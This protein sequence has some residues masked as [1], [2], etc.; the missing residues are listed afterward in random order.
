MSLRRLPDGR[1]ALGRYHSPGLTI[2]RQAQTFVPEIG[3]WRQNESED[4]EDEEEGEE[5]DDDDYD[6]DDDDADDDVDRG[7]LRATLST[8]RRSAPVA[9]NKVS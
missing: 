4:Q 1:G 8:S 6:D 9:T 2:K 7:E 5:D 3:C